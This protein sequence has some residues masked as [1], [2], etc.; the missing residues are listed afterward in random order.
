MSDGK[1]PIYFYIPQN[2]IPKDL[3]ENAD[4]YWVGFRRG[5]YCWTLQTYLHLKANHFPCHLTGTIPE[6]GIV[7]AHWDSLPQDLKPTDKLLIVCIQADR[8]RHRYA[9]IH[10]VQN[11]TALDRRIRLLGDRY[12]LA[13]KNYYMPHWSQPGLISRNSQRGDRFENIAFFGLRENLLS[14]LQSEFWQEQIQQLGLNW[15]VIE[16]FDRWHDYSNVDAILA[17]RSFIHKDYTWKPATKLY[18]S[19]H[20]G[21]PAILGAESAY[22]AERKSEL[23]YIEVNSIEEVIAALKS[24]RDRPELVKNMVENGLIRSQASQSQVITKLWQDLIDT[25][26]ILAYHHWCNSQ[27]YRSCFLW[28]RDLAMSTREWRKSLQRIRNYLGIRSL[29][30]ASLNSSDRKCMSE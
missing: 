13:G 26:L 6:E 17:V 20:A 8:S 22:Q 7:I 1:P 12:L 28:R 5:V 16:S 23:D 27:F 25:E 2:D 3:P 10:L 30:R 11:P 29:I 19:W 4:R 21:V 24:L 14:E 9:Q 18:N 15:Q